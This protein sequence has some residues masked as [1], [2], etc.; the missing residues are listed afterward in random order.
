MPDGD[1]WYD[2][3]LRAAGC[4]PRVIAHC[5]RVRDRALLFCDRS[6]VADRGLVNAG[7]LLHDIGRGI[8]HSL[9][10]AQ[11]G[12]AWCREHGIPEEV[13]RVVERHT[14]AGLTADECT[15]LRLLPVDCMPETIEEKIV[16]TAD[17]VVRGGH[18]VSIHDRL[19]ESLYLN[20]GIR[21]RIYRLWLETEQFRRS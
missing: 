17:N 10:H 15:L 6:G 18:D 21:S 8:S 4:R 2:G 14:G 13:V 12:A 11:A 19:A 5:H 16:A 20:R 1:A 9:S 7:A 3:I